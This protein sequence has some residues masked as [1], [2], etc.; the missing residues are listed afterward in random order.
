QLIRAG[1]AGGKTIPATVAGHPK[2]F[3]TFTAPSFGPVHHHLTGPDGRPARCHPHGQPRCARRH[4]PDDPAVGQP[5]DPAG[6][7][8]TGAVLWNALA[9]ALWARTTVLVNRT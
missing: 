4:D 3:A 8:Y 9:P 7:G 6:Y 1:L 5:L 2:I